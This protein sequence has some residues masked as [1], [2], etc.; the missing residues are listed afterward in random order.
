M[1][2]PPRFTWFFHPS[3]MDKCLPLPLPHPA[4]QQRLVGGEGVGKMQPQRSKLTFSVGELLA[5][6][7]KKMLEIEDNVDS[8]YI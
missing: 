8:Q 7:V 2:T 5:F 1:K 4:S 3:P 6:L